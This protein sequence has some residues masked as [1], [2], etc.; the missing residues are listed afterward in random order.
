MVKLKADFESDWIAHLRAQMTAAWG[1]MAECIADRDIPAYYFDSFHR[2]LVAKPRILK[3]SDD[4]HCPPKDN[5]GWEALQEKVH[6]GEDLNP[7]LSDDHDSPFNPDGLLAEWG[8]H[9]FHLGTKHKRRGHYH[10][11]SL[12]FALVDDNSFCAIN[13]YPHKCDW[14][15]VRILESIHRNW[16]DRISAYRVNSVT[17]ETLDKKQRYAIRAKNVNVMTGTTDGTV[18]CPVG[19]GM[20]ASGVKVESNIRADRWRNEIQ[21][22]QHTMENKLCELMPVFEQQGYAGEDELEGE[23]RITE[24][25]YQVFFPQYSILA[26]IVDEPAG[27]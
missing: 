27:A 10:A 4:F 24:A 13:V 25:G 17:G 6:K 11:D 3:V 21:R 9:H 8:V 14:T 19:G 15:D 1:T 23:L 26:N 22:L 12:V 7:H 5:A 2:K 20:S 16:P 18:Y